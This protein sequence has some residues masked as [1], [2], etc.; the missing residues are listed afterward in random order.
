MEGLLLLL[1]SLELSAL[2][3]RMGIARGWEMA[4]SFSTKPAAPCA[5]G[6]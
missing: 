5:S 4:Q 1:W 2:V 3:L 6:L